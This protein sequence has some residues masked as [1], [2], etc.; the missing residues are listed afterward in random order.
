MLARA[1]IQPVR[2]RNSSHSN[3]GSEPAREGDYPAR[4]ISDQFTFQLWERA[5]SRRR[6]A[7]RREFCGCFTSKR[8]QPRCTRQL[9]QGGWEFAFASSQ[10]GRPPRAF[11]RCPPPREAHGAGPERGHAEGAETAKSKSKSEA[12]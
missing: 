3:C 7:T 6:P 2:F 12:S 4:P 11:L 5:C 9:L 8:S 10:A 1:I